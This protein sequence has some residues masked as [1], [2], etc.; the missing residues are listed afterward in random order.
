VDAFTDSRIKVV[1]KNIINVQPEKTFTEQWREGKGRKKKL[2]YQTYVA[3]YFDAA[4]HR[5]FMQQIIEETCRL[6]ETQLNTA[7]ANAR[8]GNLFLAI[9]QIKSAGQHLEPLTEI[10][11]LTPED[12]TA[13][14][15]LSGQMQNQIAGLLNALRIASCGDKQTTRWGQAPAEPLGIEVFW[16][17][18][19]L[20]HPLPGLPV[21]F[22][23]LN[24][25]ALFNPH[26]QTDAN[27]R[28]L[29]NIQEISSPGRIEFEARVAFPDG[30]PVAQSGLR[31]T[32]LPDN[33]AIVRVIE[34]NLG[35]NVEIPE[36]GNLLMQTLTGA[37]F[38][39]LE[40][41]PF[42]TLTEDQIENLNPADIQKTVTGNG[43]DLILLAAVA[44]SQPNRIQDGF[45]FARARGVLKVYSLTKQAVV[46]NYLI[47]D[48]NAGNTPENAGMKAIKKVSDALI[49]K[50]AEEIGL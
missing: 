21:E 33:K 18:D 17:E 7:V 26:S 5:A 36:L 35:H 20:R 22:T 34:T 43:A 28:A 1:S 9:D 6:G 29:C 39:I 16:V 37:G 10:T 30:Y 19:T 4:A 13:I 8:R 31:I 41:N 25:K 45:Y 27:G 32:L 2:L 24:G 38:T 48:K 23:L 11:G 12:L 42:T 46:G 3:V 40:T 50:F 49:R 15:Q 14:R 44:S 47:E